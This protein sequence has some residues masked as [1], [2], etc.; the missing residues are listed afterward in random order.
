[1]TVLAQERIDK[2]EDQIRHIQRVGLIGELAAG[3]AHDFNNI[4]AI[5]LGN[6]AI[7][8]RLL[9]PEVSP[10]VA[11]A[12]GG[13]QSATLRGQ[14][15]IQRIM[16][17]ARRQGIDTKPVNLGGVVSSMSELIQVAVSKRNKVSINAP[18]NLWIVRAD[19]SSFENVIINLCINARDAMPEG[20]DLT[21]TLANKVVGETTDTVA[22]GDYVT[23]A[24]QDTGVGIPKEMRDK[25]FEP[26]FTTKEEGQ[27]TGLGLST[28]QNFVLQN[29]GAV[30]LECGES[31]GTT[32]TI[33]L[34]RFRGVPT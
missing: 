1:E 32:F 16:T 4:L 18:A 15:L 28:V 34:P 10:P 12:V 2:Q 9:G 8:N 33:Y 17:F 22:A 27:G 5:V 20:G 26:F 23:V 3:F 29:Y 19:V 31:A 11:K 24:V 7:V 6:V 25:I 21:I 14:T 13:I 30:T